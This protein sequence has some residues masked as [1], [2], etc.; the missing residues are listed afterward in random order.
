MICC[1]PLIS[2]PKWNNCRNMGDV[3]WCFFSQGKKPN[4]GGHLCRSGAE[5]RAQQGERRSIPSILLFSTFHS[6]CGG[7]VCVEQTGFSEFPAD[8][9]YS[10]CSCRLVDPGSF[11]SGCPLGVGGT[12]SIKKADRQHR[13]HIDLE[14]QSL[15]SLRFSYPPV[16]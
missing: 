11:T 4:P 3:V 9:P 1:I 13:D 10:L 14:I 8:L 12:G 2:S 7:H 15:I 6:S 5:Q 16:R